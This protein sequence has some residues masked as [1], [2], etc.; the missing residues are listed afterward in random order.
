M[1]L[2]EQR[3]W[4]TWHFSS[5]YLF[6]IVTRLTSMYRPEFQYTNPPHLT[7]FSIF[8]C[9]TFWVHMPTG[10]LTLTYYPGSLR[11]S[12]SISQRMLIL[13]SEHSNSLKMPLIFIYC[14]PQ[15]PFRLCPERILEEVCL[16]STRIKLI[17]HINQGPPWMPGPFGCGLMAP[18][19]KDVCFGLASK[20]FHFQQCQLLSHRELSSVACC[21]CSHLFLSVER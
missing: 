15:G 1:I 10:S 19:P 8:K 18:A 5:F 6:F 3:S 16:S 2:N 4:E 12:P 14:S 11:T 7:H 9:Q 17:H 20:G 21:G 13:E